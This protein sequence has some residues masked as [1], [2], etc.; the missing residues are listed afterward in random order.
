[1]FYEKKSHNKQNKHDFKKK[2]RCFDFILVP[3][4]PILPYQEKSRKITKKMDF[5]PTFFFFDSYD[6]GESH[7]LTHYQ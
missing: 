3:K 6:I 4:D 5:L 7:C 2:N 1:M